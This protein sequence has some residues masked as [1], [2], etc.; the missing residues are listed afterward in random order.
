MSNLNVTP[1]YL[2]LLH[3]LSRESRH[4]VCI[5][6]VLFISF[7]TCSVPA[8]DIYGICVRSFSSLF[9]AVCHVLILEIN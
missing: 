2:F 9:F 6:L 3:L 8:P 1:M 7:A 5:I 4:F